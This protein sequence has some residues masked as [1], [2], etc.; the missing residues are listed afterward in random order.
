M[1]ITPGTLCL[2]VKKDLSPFPNYFY[3]FTFGL[4]R[5]FTA[6]A[7]IGLL[8]MSCELFLLLN[9]K[10][11]KQTTCLSVSLNSDFIFKFFIVNHKLTMGQRGNIIRKYF[12][13]V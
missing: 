5:N 3:S 2:P 8:S 9:H 1:E 11:L 7:H 6:Q 4:T 13:V 10:R 12:P